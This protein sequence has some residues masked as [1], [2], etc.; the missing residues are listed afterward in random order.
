MKENTFIQAR[1][2]WL[3]GCPLRPLCSLTKLTKDRLRLHTWFWNNFIGIASHHQYSEIEHF[4]HEQPFR[5]QS[6]K[7]SLMWASWKGYQDSKCKSKEWAD[8]HQWNVFWN[9]QLQ[10]CTMQA[11]TLARPQAAVAVVLQP[12]TKNEQFPHHGYQWLGANR[13]PAQGSATLA[14]QP[15]RFI[16]TKRHANVIDS[17]IIS[18]KQLWW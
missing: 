9:Q 15:G 17:L 8:Q 12:W 13:W 6:K 16:G 4:K 11:K 5:D 7:M 10:T 18:E 2:C 1:S 14:P 3:W